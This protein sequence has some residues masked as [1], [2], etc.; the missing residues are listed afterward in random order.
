MFKPLTTVGAVLV[1]LIACGISFGGK[2]H[3]DYGNHMSS[4]LGKDGKHPLATINNHHSHAEVKN[5]KIINM[6]V[7]PA[8]KTP[9]VE[10]AVRVKKVKTKVNVQGRRHTFV[11]DDLDGLA[12]KSNG[13]ILFMGFA[14]LCPFDNHWY[15]FW[16]PVQMMGFSDND[17]DVEEDDGNEG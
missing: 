6:H 8:R 5:G 16:F 10:L 13:Q 4:K 15:Y 14:Y 7:T 11:F 17:P 9:G 3:A 12:P 1:V 2:K